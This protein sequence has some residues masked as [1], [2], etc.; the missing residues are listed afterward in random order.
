VRPSESSELECFWMPL[1]DGG[2][3]AAGVFRKP[4]GQETV[5]ARFCWKREFY[6][7][8]LIAFGHFHADRYARSCGLLGHEAGDQ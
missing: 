8:E 1:I 6:E 2:S 4:E 3:E 7:H 5:R